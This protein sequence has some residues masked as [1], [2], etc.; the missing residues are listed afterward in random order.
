MAAYFAK[1]AKYCIAK[2][3]VDY[4]NTVLVIK[5]QRCVECNNGNVSNCTTRPGSVDGPGVP[6]TDLIIYV[7]AFDCS[8][9]FPGALAFAS[10]CQMESV[11]DR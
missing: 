10:A 6:D 7:S 1:N 4:V 5:L 11:L 2:L 8:L 3:H 9:R